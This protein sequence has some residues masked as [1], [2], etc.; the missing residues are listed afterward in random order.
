MLHLRDTGWVARRWREDYAPPGIGGVRKLIA[1]IGV[2]M[3]A[4]GC[5]DASAGRSPDSPAVL[6]VT[7]SA[8]PFTEVTAGPV[9]ALIPHQW[10]PMLAQLLGGLQEGVIAA[11]RPQDWGRGVDGSAAGMAALWVDVARVGVPSDYYYM[12]ATG[13]ALEQLTHS[14]SCHAQTQR[15]FVDH[16]PSYFDGAAG[17]PG[18]YVARGHGTCSEGDAPTRYA[19]FVAAP[20]FG[21]MRTVGIPSSGLY[22]VVAVL[23]DSSRAQKLLDTILRATTFGGAGVRD[24]IRAAQQQA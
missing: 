15:I 20:G 18:D 5:R 2:A 12:A 7:P 16:R 10:H 14:A 11:P 21:P 1:T 3:L 22:V 17:S 6:V 23:P 13:P 4:A 19:Y 8:T 24:F 9:R